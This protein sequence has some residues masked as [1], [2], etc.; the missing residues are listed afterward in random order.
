MAFL[1]SSHENS[2][3][4]LFGYVLSTAHQTYTVSWSHCCVTGVLSLNT[5]KFTAF[6]TTEKAL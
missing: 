6:F 5:E 4:E 3:T 2:S 1:T